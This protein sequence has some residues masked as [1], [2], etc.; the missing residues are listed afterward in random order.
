M[1]TLRL[2]LSLVFATILATAFI[3]ADD[4]PAEPAKEFAERHGFHAA[5]E[6]RDSGRPIPNGGG[7][8]PEVS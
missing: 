5:V 7:P 1:K 4:K 8:I 2:L 3:R 6:W